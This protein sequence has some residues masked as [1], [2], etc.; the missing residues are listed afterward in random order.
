[1]AVGATRG[2]II[3]GVFGDAFRMA[4]PGLLVGGLLATGTAVAMR[5]T[6]LGLSPVDPISLFFV[7]GLLLLVVFAAS[8]PPALKASGIQ[9]TE[10]L[11]RD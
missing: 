5:S 10:A 4:A 8:L 3:R 9:P 6:L 1:M 2:V 7:G 11:R